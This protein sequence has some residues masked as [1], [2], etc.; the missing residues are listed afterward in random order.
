MKLSHTA[1]DIYALII[2]CILL[3]VY[4]L[5]RKRTDRINKY[6]IGWN[7]FL[8]LIF[9]FDFLKWHLRGKIDYLLQFKIVYYSIFVIVITMFIFYHLYF[10]EYIRKWITVSDIYKYI[11]IPIALISLI[12]WFGFKDSRLFFLIAYNAVNVE[13]PL[14]NYIQL[15]AF[16]L[17]VY[18]M[19]FVFRHLAKTG[20]KEALMIIFLNF[21]LVLAIVMEFLWDIT[22]LYLG[23]LLSLIL[24]FGIITTEQSRILSETKV[25]LIENRIAIA[26]SQIQPHFLYNTLGTIEVLCYKDPDMAGQA[27]NYFANY[28]RMNLEAMNRTKP[29]SFKRELKH[30]ETYL[31]IEKLRFQEKLNVIYNI[32]DCDFQV[33]ALSIQPIVENAVKHGICGKE[34]PGTIKIEVKDNREFYEIIISDDGPGFD[35][36]SLQKFQID[37]NSGKILNSDEIHQSLVLDDGRTHLGIE[38]VRQRLGLMVG[39]SLEINSEIGMGTN[40]VIIIAKQSGK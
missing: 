14:Y 8:I 29:I 19:L 39:A 35:V 40:A 25:T 11:A 23:T 17:I 37:Y 30:I 13:G 24:L 33:P 38:N 20:K 2:S 4:I 5:Q 28:M 32:A 34:E 26:M 31:W 27:I 16:L 15:P 10:V 6:L 21:L 9:L 3:I 12:V 22:I 1:L 36:N 18:N 7:S